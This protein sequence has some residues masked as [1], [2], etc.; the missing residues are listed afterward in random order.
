MRTQVERCRAILERMRVDAGEMR[1]ER[2]APATVDELVAG[3]LAGLPT[4]IAVRADVDP[5]LSAVSL[6]VPPRAVA[7]AICGVLKNAQDASPAGAAV[8]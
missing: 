1:G 8:D 2:L 5:A 7:E 3:S 4:E 6:H